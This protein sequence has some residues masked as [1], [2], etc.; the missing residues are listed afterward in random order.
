MLSM[1]FLLLTSCA[2]SHSDGCPMIKTYTPEEQDKAYV[3]LAHLSPGSE[4]GVM[5]DDYALL[6]QESRDCN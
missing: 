6:R 2:T 1:P 3:E 4:I 5:I